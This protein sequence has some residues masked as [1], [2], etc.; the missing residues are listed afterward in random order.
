MLSS[1]VLP[2]EKAGAFSFCQE[3]AGVR[4]LREARSEDLLACLRAGQKMPRSVI[5]EKTS[6]FAEMHSSDEVGQVVQKG[7]PKDQSV[8]D[9][10][11]EDRNGE[12]DNGISGHSS[13]KR[14]RDEFP[15]PEGG[16][17][18]RSVP[19]VRR[20]FRAYADIAVHQNMSFPIDIRHGGQIR[21]TLGETEEI[22]VHC[23]HVSVLDGA[24]S[25][26][27]ADFLEIREIPA[28]E[29]GN[30]EVQNT[31]KAFRERDVRMVTFGQEERQGRKDNH[32][33]EQ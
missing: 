31:L 14:W 24:K 3:W 12:N 30:L 5:E 28:G 8:E 7:R 10:L 20:I 17:E 22:P 6:R 26:N 1:F 33:E 19:E 29:K 27:R 18:I 11:S 15:S 9:F 21:P 25:G 32:E 13:H 23:L 16:L 2:L 4:V